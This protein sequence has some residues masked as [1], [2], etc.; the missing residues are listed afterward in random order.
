VQR[1]EENSIFLLF[2]IPSVSVI[3]GAPVSHDY[4][5]LVP[6]MS[7]Y[8]RNDDYLFRERPSCRILEER[9]VR[10]KNQV[11]KVV[12]KEHTAPAY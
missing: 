4:E 2:K 1:K 10:T 9:F 8:F 6:I 12:A 11:N 7:S 5:R 3:D